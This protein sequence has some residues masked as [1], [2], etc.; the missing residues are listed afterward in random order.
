MVGGIGRFDT[1]AYSDGSEI[2]RSGPYFIFSAADK[3]ARDQSR[4]LGLTCYVVVRENKDGQLLPE[5]VRVY[6]RAR[7]MPIKNYI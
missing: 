3:Y 7:Q 2:D 6:R 1:I 4:L 5:I